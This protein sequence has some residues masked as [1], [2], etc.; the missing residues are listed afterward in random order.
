MSHEGRKGGKGSHTHL[1]LESRLGQCLAFCTPHFHRQWEGTVQTSPWHPPSLDGIPQEAAQELRSSDG[2]AGADTK[3][4]WPGVFQE[5]GSKGGIGPLQNR[6]G[7][8]WEDSRQLGL[9][10]RREEQLEGP[11]QSNPTLVG[12]CSN[13]PVP[14]V[15][16]TARPLS[17]WAAADLQSVLNGA[18]LHRCNR[19]PHG[20]RDI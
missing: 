18:Q 10:V 4:L 15:G 8:V 13:V 2:R 12:Y 16:G 11:Y 20:A 9:A 17:R 6:L 7:H 19:A 14:A 1:S 5:D 3:L